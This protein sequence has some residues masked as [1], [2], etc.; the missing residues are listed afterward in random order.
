MA[1]RE[2]VAPDTLEILGSLKMGVDE[3][4]QTRRPIRNGLHKQRFDR[5]SRA[6]R[7]PEVL[8]RWA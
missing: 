6:A 1:K 7:A 5:W 8:A 2:I 4:E 3:N